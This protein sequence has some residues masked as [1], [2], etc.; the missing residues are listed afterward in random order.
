MRSYQENR[1][2]SCNFSDIVNQNL[3]IDSPLGFKVKSRNYPWALL[4]SAL[5]NPNEFYL[6]INYFTDVY[7]TELENVYLQ[8]HR[9]VRT[10]VLTRKPYNDL[11]CFHIIFFL[12]YSLLSCI[13]RC[14]CCE[15]GFFRK[16]SDSK[17]KHRVKFYRLRL[18]HVIT[19]NV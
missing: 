2:W 4:I 9:T 17:F 14:G 5:G 3:R 15:G 19:T 1:F 11:N 8:S 18:R 6:E 7:T 13:T 16:M 12:D 10:P